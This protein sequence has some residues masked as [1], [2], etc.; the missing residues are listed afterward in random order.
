MK[1]SK[2]HKKTFPAVNIRGDLDDVKKL[3]EVISK[4]KSV[5]IFRNSDDGTCF[6][7]IKKNMGEYIRTNI[8]RLEKDF[9]I[10]ADD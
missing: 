4:K 5:V 10:I 8:D 1:T 6:V 9:R 3:V 2:N 7:E